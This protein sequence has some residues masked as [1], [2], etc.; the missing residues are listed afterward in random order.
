MAINFNLDG[1]V[2]FFSESGDGATQRV[3][4]GTDWLPLYTVFQAAH[5][6]APPSPAP[7]AIFALPQTDPGQ[8]GAVFIVNNTLKVSQGNAAAVQI[9]STGP[10][11]A[12]S[13]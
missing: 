6:G 13:L 11:G 8:T 1:S 3:A 7:V 5:V 4:A 12:V 10:V 9:G 2:T